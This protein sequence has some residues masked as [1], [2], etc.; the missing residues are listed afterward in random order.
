[1][2]LRSLLI[3]LQ[4]SYLTPPMA[5]AIFYMRAIAPESIATSHMYRGVFPFIALQFVTLVLVMR[6]P[7]IALWLPSQVL[8][9]K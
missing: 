2:V 3:V 6:F 7:E 1:M 9:F 5:P 4:T 8:G